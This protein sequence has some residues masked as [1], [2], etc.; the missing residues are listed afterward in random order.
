MQEWRAPGAAKDI[1]P[2]TH[3]LKIC[4]LLFKPSAVYQIVQVRGGGLLERAI[5]YK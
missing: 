2:P 5:L 4:K 1:P 3:T